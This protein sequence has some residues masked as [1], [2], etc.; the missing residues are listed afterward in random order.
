MNFPADPTGGSSSPTT[1]TSASGLSGLLG[2]LAGILAPP[3][4]DI[5]KPPAAV[6]PAPKATFN[7]QE[8]ALI[9]AAGNWENISGALTK[10]LAYCEEGWADPWLFGCNDTLYTAGRLSEKF[11]QYVVYACGDGAVI[12]Q[13]VANGLVASANFAVGADHES[14]NNFDTLKLRSGL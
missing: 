1:T 11:N 13:Q 8:K 7:V 10:A 14:S 2:T 4:P 12:T 9:S 6:S 3:P 5:T